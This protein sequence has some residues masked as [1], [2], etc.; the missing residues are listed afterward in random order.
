MDQREVRRDGF[1]IENQRLVTGPLTLFG[2]EEIS[3]IYS[4]ILEVMGIDLDQPMAF[5][6]AFVIKFII[7]ILW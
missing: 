6:A 4:A 2:A 5:S 3:Q 1:S 7:G